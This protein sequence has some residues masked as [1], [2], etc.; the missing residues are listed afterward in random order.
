[1]KNECHQLISFKTFKTLLGSYWQYH[2]LE[3]ELKPTSLP[4][5]YTFH[6]LKQLLTFYKTAE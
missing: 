5:Y 6:L 1:M 3:V 2:I 4:V